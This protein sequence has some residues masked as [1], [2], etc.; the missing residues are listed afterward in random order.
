MKE[1]VGKDKKVFFRFS[2]IVSMMIVAVVGVKV[3]AENML[4]KISSI[5][6]NNCFSF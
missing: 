2:F 1:S 3:F 4:W 6:K 5:M